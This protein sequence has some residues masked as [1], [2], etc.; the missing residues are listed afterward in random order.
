[1]WPPHSSP[2]AVLSRSAMPAPL[3]PHTRMTT[4]T[5]AGAR[6]ASRI[7]FSFALAGMAIVPAPAAG[8]SAGDGSAA[9]P[10][11]VAT[12][13]HLNEV[14]NHLGAHFVQTTDIDLGVAPWNDGEGW[15]STI[16]KVQ[17]SVRASPP[18]WGLLP[19]VKRKARLRCLI[20]RPL[21]IGISVPSGGSWQAAATRILR[22][23][24]V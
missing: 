11:Q 14:R 19:E 15:R 24:Q 23:K 5:S 18:A 21:P 4:P 2:P 17:P 20:R 9:S 3:H 13:D 8:I 7:V 6:R 10:Y 12:A 1:M 22:G 16:T